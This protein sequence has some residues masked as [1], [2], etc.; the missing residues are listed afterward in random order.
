[1]EN[2]K[3]LCIFIYTCSYS[4]IY[5]YYHILD[6]DRHHTKEHTPSLTQIGKTTEP[7]NSD[8]LLIHNQA[9]FPTDQ[10]A[11]PMSAWPTRPTICLGLGSNRGGLIIASTPF[12]LETRSVIITIKN[13][14]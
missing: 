3:K 5:I 7:T 2:S 12:V 4:Y 14:I 9:I 13:E 8:D 1:M 6:K 10:V 11:S